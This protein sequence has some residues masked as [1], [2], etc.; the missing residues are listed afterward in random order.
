MK[1]KLIT[2]LICIF[3]LHSSVVFASASTSLPMVVD[4][5]Q[6]LTYDEIS[7]LE[8]TAQGLRAEYEM[9]VVILTV[10]NLG[11][12]SIQDYA[13][14]YFDDNGYGYGESY[15]GVLFLLSMEEREWYISTCGD[16]V[17]AITDYGVQQLGDTA[18][19]YLSAGRYY[20]GFLAYLNALEDYLIAYQAGNPVDGYAD[21]SENY[22]HGDR[23]ETVYYG[24]DS[25]P[26]LL[27]SLIIGVIV[28]VITIGVMRASMNTK[29]KQHGASV[30]M[31]PGSYHLRT[32]QDLFLYS[33]VT[34]TRRQENKPSG[35]GS[36]VHR[37]SGGRRH[38]GG[39]GKF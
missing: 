8:D 38:G 28:A 25:S 16:A 9:D 5:A 18:V 29:R 32:H 19:G 1:R 21:Y 27:L 23:Q 3:L 37:S 13:D 12:R 22:Y 7:F 15:N 24:E 17:Y 30:Y 35:G 10:D 6:L 26:N 20:D 14:D 36:S 31:Q 33:N 39:G 11:E 4:T 34:K 2:V